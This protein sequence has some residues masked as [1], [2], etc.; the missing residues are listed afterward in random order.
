MGFIQRLEGGKN[1]IAGAGGENRTLIQSLK[2][3][4]PY[5]DVH[6]LAPKSFS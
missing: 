4:I 3:L 1:P 5:D 2:I 6:L